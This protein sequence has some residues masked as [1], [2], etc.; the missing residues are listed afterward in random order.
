MISSLKHN[1][2]TEK[3]RNYQDNYESLLYHN[4]C[5]GWFID[6]IQIIYFLIFNMLEHQNGFL[7]NSHGTSRGQFA[8]Q[9]FFLQIGEINLDID[10]SYSLFMTRLKSIHSKH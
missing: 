8:R 3:L 9:L 2:L 1:N 6:S 7:A 10:K 4:K 5:C